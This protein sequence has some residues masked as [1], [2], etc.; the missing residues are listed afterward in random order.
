V[1][2]LVEVTTASRTKPLKE[3]EVD[4]LAA[5]AQFVKGVPYSDDRTLVLV[6]RD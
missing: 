4:L 6:R 2:R 1:D 5:L 3:I